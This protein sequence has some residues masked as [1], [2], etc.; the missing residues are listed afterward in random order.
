MIFKLFIRNFYLTNAKR[1]DFSEKENLL[2]SSNEPDSSKLFIPPYIL[3]S[4]D[5]AV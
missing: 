5:G 1:I 4:E 3:V 2:L